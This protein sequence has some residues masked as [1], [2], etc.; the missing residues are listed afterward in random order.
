MI[1]TLCTSPRPCDECRK[2]AKFR[3]VAKRGHEMQLCE[4]CAPLLIATVVEGI[5]L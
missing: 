3:I 5:N 4:A 2:N 1:L